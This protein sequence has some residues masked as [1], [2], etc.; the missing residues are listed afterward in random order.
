MSAKGKILLVDDDVEF[1]NST[2]DLLEA[3]GYTVISAHDG[4]SGLER[5]RKE[6][7][8]L[9]V[10]DVMMAT[11]TE[12]FD[13]ARK[14][15]SLPELHTM[16]VLLVTGIRK[17]MALK[18]RLEPDETWLP[19]S[20]IMEK[21][22]DPATFVANVGELLRKRQ[23]MD[24]RAVGT[25]TTVAGL[26]AAKGSSLWTIEPAATGMEAVAMM[27]KYRV[28]ALPVVEQGKL[29]GIVTE[30]DCARKLILDRRAADQTPVRDIMTGRVM[31]VSPQQ[32]VGQCMGV[33]TH[34]HVRHLPVKDGEKLVGIIS[35]GDVVRAT[36]A[37]KNYLIHQLETY[38]TVG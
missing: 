23:E 34:K 8:D 29:V 33:M 18:F 22:V 4:T 6:R 3:H 17:E 37:E 15:P 14:L 21:P 31:C 35:I 7:P 5:A 25:E 28:G 30:R 19:V 36:I 27:D 24:Y 2:T 38:I 16:P 1:V 12:G 20:Q 10:L 32:T 26:L 11:K 9:M 13:V